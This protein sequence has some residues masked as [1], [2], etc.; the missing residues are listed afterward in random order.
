VAIT[1]EDKVLLVKTLVGNGKW[2]MPGGGIRKGETPQDCASREILEETGLKVTPVE[3]E[4]L[5]ESVYRSNG[6]SFKCYRYGIELKSPKKPV[7]IT[8]E[9]AEAQWMPIDSLNA[10]NCDT[11]VIRLLEAWSDLH[12]RVRM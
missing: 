7:I 5:G 1:H 2:K 3:L 10:N 12:R 4:P 11:E 6:F 9:I 8:K